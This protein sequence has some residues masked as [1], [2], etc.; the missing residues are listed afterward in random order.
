MS[1]KEARRLEHKAE[2]E[3]RRMERDELARNLEKADESSRKRLI[4]FYA[5][6]R[7]HKRK[8]REVYEY[9]RNLIMLYGHV[10]KEILEADARLKIV[11]G[12][13]FDRA[14]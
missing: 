3:R 4:T 11:Q 6:G 8:D 7:P 13:A 2:M 12:P 9:G 1:S 14:T 10:P 5:A